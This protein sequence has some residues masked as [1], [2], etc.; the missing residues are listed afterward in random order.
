MQDLPY[1][2]L[3]LIK[4]DC[5][6]EGVNLSPPGSPPSPLPGAMWVTHLTDGPTMEKLIGSPV[7]LTYGEINQWLEQPS[8]HPIQAGVSDNGDWY[9]ILE[10]WGI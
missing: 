3:A 2:A 10:N 4:N 6:D 9:V 8:D 5:F 1:Q 7:A